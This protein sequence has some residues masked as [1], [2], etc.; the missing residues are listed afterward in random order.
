[1]RGDD[2]IGGEVEDCRSGDGERERERGVGTGNV[3]RKMRRTGKATLF[4]LQNKQAVA[5][6]ISCQ[7]HVLSIDF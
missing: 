7:N 1:M 2:S 6:K 3:I 5:L 4:F